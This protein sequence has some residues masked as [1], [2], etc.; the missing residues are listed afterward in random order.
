MG[1]H[2][3]LEESILRAQEL[4]VANWHTMSFGV[5]GSRF[6]AHGP[7]VMTQ[8]EDWGFREKD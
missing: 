7:G 6:R 3:H 8:E 1:M 2:I 5:W 4:R